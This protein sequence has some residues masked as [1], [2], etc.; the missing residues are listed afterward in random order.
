VTQLVSVSI[1]LTDIL[2]LYLH[3]QPNT[4]LLP[5]P[6]LCTTVTF[7]RLEFHSSLRHGVIFSVSVSSTKES[8]F[9]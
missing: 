6:L 3:D 7:C 2:V 5:S 4:V 8:F 1:A 9:N